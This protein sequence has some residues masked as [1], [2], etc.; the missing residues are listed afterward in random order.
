MEAIVGVLPE[1]SRFC[2]DLSDGDDFQN[3]FE[4]TDDGLV[5]LDTTEDGLC[6]FAYQSKGE[7]R[8][9]LHSAAEHLNVPVEQVKPAVCLLWPLSISDDEPARLSI[10]DDALTFHCNTRSGAE[11]TLTENALLATIE[12]VYGL[13]ARTQVLE[14]EDNGCEQATIVLQP[15]SPGKRVRGT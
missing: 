1:V 14:A 12:Q 9:G 10:A 11:E 5:S 15:A 2:P 4:E 7:L 13:S 8:C 3:V 6:V